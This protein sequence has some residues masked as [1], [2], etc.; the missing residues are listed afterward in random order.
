MRHKALTLLLLLLLTATLQAQS[1]LYPVEM[2]APGILG[3]VMRPVRDGVEVMNLLA[4][5]PADSCGMRVGD[6]I[7]GDADVSAPEALGRFQPREPG[8]RSV[9]RVR[10]GT[11]TMTFTVT[12][13]PLPNELAAQWRRRA[14]ANGAQN[15][16]VERVQGR[17]LGLRL[18][19]PVAPDAASFGGEVKFLR[20]SQPIARG[21]IL[22]ANGAWRLVLEV[23][24]GEAVPEVGD[25]GVAL[26]RDPARSEVGSRW[27]ARPTTGAPQ[28]TEPPT[29]ASTRHVRVPRSLLDAHLR[30]VQSHYSTLLAAVP[31][32][33]RGVAAGVRLEVSDSPEINALA[34]LSKGKPVV[35]VTRGMG[36]VILLLSY[37]LSAAP[38]R[39]VDATMEEVVRLAFAKALGEERLPLPVG[40]VQRMRNPDFVRSVS[41][42]AA[43]MYLFI[44]GHE[45]GHHCLGHCSAKVSSSTL[46]AERQKEK[47][48]DQFGAFSVRWAKLD[49]APV[50]LFA[51]FMALAETME[52]DRRPEFL[53]DH[54]DW[55]SRASFLEGVFASV[56]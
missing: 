38:E 1:S 34:Y 39:S 32:E 37:L 23:P 51:R 22:S 24:E 48:A 2:P 5:G 19:A 12:W 42:T 11:D 41:E 25:V 31:S 13:A 28:P 21:R 20:G 49:E 6:V 50:M 55:D 4:G 33:H 18:F 17:L 47:D 36:E 46:Y 10:R 29:T 9:L 3:I 56:R 14:Q 26:L 44:L 16:Q 30:L 8:E 40:F 27:D 35:E 53:R 54:P 7:V 52:L 43:P 15:G 45:L